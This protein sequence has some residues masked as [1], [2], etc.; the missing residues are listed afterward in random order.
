MQQTCMSKLL[1]CMS[2]LTTS[3]CAKN[4]ASSVCMPSKHLYP[5][6]RS[7]EQPP[8]ASQQELIKLIGP[9][10][11]NMHLWQQASGSYP[12]NFLPTRGPLCTPPW[13]PQ[14]S[15]VV[16][17]LQQGYKNSTQIRTHMLTYDVGALCSLHCRISLLVQTIALHP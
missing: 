8:N 15:M 1:M 12:Q 16:Y 5:G 6:C 2:N 7:C 3:D 10:L 11:R 17:M 4:N 9:S 14:G 13:W